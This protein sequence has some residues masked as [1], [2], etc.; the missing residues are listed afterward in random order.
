MSS[1]C[2]TLTT[3][4][5]VLM[6][7]MLFLFEVG[8]GGGGGESGEKLKISRC[9]L[10]KSSFY[11]N[12]SFLVST[13]VMTFCLKELRQI[14]LWIYWNWNWWQ[15]SGAKSSATVVDD[16]LP[17][18]LLSVLAVTFPFFRVSLNW[19]CI[20][21]TLSLEWNFHRIYYHSEKF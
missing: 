18:S 14:N 4:S 11:H 13:E 17:I 1:C 2:L 5:P 12:C 19:F 20:L 3:C 21:K 10:Q 16:N 6:H 7:L 15:W 9:T 8:G